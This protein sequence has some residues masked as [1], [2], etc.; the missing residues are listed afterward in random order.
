MRLLEPFLHFLTPRQSNNHKAKALHVSSVTTYIVLLL[1]FQIILTGVAKFNPGVLGYASNITV[2]DLL[3]YTN[4]QRVAA[5]QMPLKLNDQLNRAAEAKAADMFANQYW[6]HTSPQGKDPWSFITA[7]GYSY[8]FAGENLARDFGDSKSVVDAWMNSPS[9]REN[10]LNSR[11]A[12]VG[13]AVVN[14]KYNGY[15]TTLVVQM[16]GAQ[17]ARTPTVEETSVPAQVQETS[18]ESAKQSTPAGMILNTETGNSQPKIDAFGLTKTVSVALTVLL[19]GVLVVDSA[20][21]YRRKTVRLS[22]HN[23][24]HLVLLIAL[25]VALNLIGRGIVL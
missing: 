2:T 19:L 10:L 13:F 20:L 11:Y 5:G 22:G 16:F 25:L 6:A 1:V 7:A 9:H 4:D 15:E 18:S 23:L 17:S 12:D 14:G 3:K 21:V 8:L 24:A